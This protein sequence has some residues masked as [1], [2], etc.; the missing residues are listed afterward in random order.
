MK[1]LFSLMVVRF[2]L[3]ADLVDNLWTNHQLNNGV[4]K[5]EIRQIIERF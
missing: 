2:K 3:W 1:D 5:K 4:L